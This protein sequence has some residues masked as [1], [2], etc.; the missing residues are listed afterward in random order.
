MHGLVPVVFVVALLIADEV[1]K[2]R[3]RILKK[4]KRE[5]EKHNNNKES[6]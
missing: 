2:S 1:C 4:K 6:Q 5:K 3:P